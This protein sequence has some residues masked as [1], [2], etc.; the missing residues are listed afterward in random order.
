MRSCRCEHP[1][2]RRDQPCCFVSKIGVW[3]EGRRRRS[4]APNVQPGRRFNI[5]GAPSN[6]VRQLS[7]V[8]PLMMLV[9]DC[10]GKSTSTP[11]TP[12]TPDPRDTMTKLYDKPPMR[13]LGVSCRRTNPRATIL[14]CSLGTTPF[15]ENPFVNAMCTSQKRGNQCRHQ[16][17][18]PATM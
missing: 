13:S 2:V 18:H 11:R 3:G 1:A 15:A 9:L 17:S 5:V 14:A 7:R 4:E 6:H 16:G 12:S 8:A 10:Q